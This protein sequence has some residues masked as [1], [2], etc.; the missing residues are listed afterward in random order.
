MIESTLRP[1]DRTA[2][3]GQQALQAEHVAPFPVPASRLYSMMDSYGH[4]QLQ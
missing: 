2:S 1:S 4:F 3:M